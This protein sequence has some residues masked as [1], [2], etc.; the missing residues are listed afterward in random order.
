MEFSGKQKDFA[1][2][3]ALSKILYTCGKNSFVFKENP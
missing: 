3:V 2:A 1:E